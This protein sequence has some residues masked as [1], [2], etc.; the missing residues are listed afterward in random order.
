[1]RSP[2]LSNPWMRPLAPPIIDPPPNALR[3]DRNGRASRAASFG[4]RQSRRHRLP[5]L[6]RG[7]VL[8][9]LRTANHGS[10][11]DRSQGAERRGDLAGRVTPELVRRVLA[12]GSAARLQQLPLLARTGRF[13]APSMKRHPGSMCLRLRCSSLDRIDRNGA[14]NEWQHAGRRRTGGIGWDGTPSIWRCSL[15]H[16]AL[17]RVSRPVRIM[18]AAA[19]AFGRRPRP[20]CRSADASRLVDTRIAPDAGAR[21]SDSTGGAG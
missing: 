5:S 18:L 12:E 10:H 2:R 8:A 15:G 16:Q 17:H 21:R 4:D 14:A 1:M 7:S 3:G 6:S 20:L 9:A 11:N 13:V 19:R